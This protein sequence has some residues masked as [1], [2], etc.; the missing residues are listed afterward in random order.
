LHTSVIVSS[1]S[2]LSTIEIANQQSFMAS[3]Q[4]DSCIV[5]FQP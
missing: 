4:S 2:S 3:E 5:N 1:L